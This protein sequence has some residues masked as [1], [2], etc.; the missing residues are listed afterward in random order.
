MPLRFRQEVQAL[1][2][3]ICLKS[4]AAILAAGNRQNYLKI[5][6]LPSRTVFFNAL[7]LSQVREDDGETDADFRKLGC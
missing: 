1:P 5:K 2:R 4:A 3:D 7:L 6:G